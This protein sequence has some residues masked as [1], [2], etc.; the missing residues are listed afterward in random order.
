MREPISPSSLLHPEVASA[1]AQAN[2]TGPRALLASRGLM[3][4]AQGAWDPGRVMGQQRQP[5]MGGQDMHHMPPPPPVLVLRWALNGRL[6]A[7]S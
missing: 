2:P 7:S 1:S 4:S 6:R 3:P 5:V